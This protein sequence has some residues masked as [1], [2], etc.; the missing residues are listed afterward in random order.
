[1]SALLILKRLISI[2]CSA[3]YCILV[4][5]HKLIISEILYAG[6]RF[7]SDGWN[8]IKNVILSKSSN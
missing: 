7:N 1:M 3:I 8:L 5:K 4:N 2:M 6:S